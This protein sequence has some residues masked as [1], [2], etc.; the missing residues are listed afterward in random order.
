MSNI[1]MSNIKKGKIAIG[2]VLP[3][4]IKTSVQVVE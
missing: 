2:K 3:M 1:Q 4:G